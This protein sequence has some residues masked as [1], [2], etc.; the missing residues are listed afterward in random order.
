MAEYVDEVVIPYDRD[1]G[2]VLFDYYGVDTARRISEQSPRDVLEI[3]AGTGIVTRHLRDM[4]PK[5]TH[6]T[7]VDI[8]CASCLF[9]PSLPFMGAWLEREQQR[10]TAPVFPQ[11]N[12]AD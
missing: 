10:V 8:T 4:L 1:L 2:P 9:R 11:G 6:L 5:E 12:G 7:A 3:A